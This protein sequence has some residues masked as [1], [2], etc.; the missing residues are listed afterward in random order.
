MKL[1]GCQPPF[2]SVQRSCTTSLRPAWHAVSA[3]RSAAVSATP[4]PLLVW[5]AD[6]LTRDSMMVSLLLLGHRWRRWAAKM[7]TFE[8][9]V[10]PAREAARLSTAFYR[11]LE[12]ELG[13]GLDGAGMHIQPVDDGQR[14]IVKLPT[15]EAVQAFARFASRFTLPPSEGH[16]PP[17]HAPTRWT[18]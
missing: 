10:V 17:F 13:A 6:W 8:T 9:D 16:S 4:P 5:C 1:R 11:F 7:Y 2:R 3:S 12:H 15:A 18:S 14:V